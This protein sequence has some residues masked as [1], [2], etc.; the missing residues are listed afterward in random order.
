MQTTIYDNWGVAHVVNGDYA[1]FP[2]FFRLRRLDSDGATVTEEIIREPGGWSDLKLTLER[3]PDWHG[4]SAEYSHNDSSLSFDHYSGRDLITETFTAEGEDA[5]LLLQYGTRD[6]D[7]YIVE[8]EGRL[9]L[10]AYKRRKGRVFCPLERKSLASMVRSRW[11]TATDLFSATD[12]DNRASTPPLPLYVPLSPQ[13]IGERFSCKTT[14][15][16]R[17]EMTFNGDGDIYTQFNTSQPQ[18]SEIEDF[19]SGK[20]QGIAKSDGPVS[21]DEW[22]FKFATSGSR[23]I[24]LQLD[25][26]IWVSVKKRPI[27]LTKAKIT[28][29]TLRTRLVLKRANGNTYE[30]DVTTPVRVGRAA[31]PANNSFASADIAD[32]ATT[33]G[34]VFTQTVNVQPGDRLY[35]FGEFKFTHNLNEL[36]QVQVTMQTVTQR[37]D[38]EG[39]SE[40]R[41]TMAVGLTP[42]TALDSAVRLATG[43]TNRLRSNYY[44]AVSA[45]YPTAGPGS[46]R[47]LTTGYHLR[48]FPADANALA[49]PF[50]T[51]LQKLLTGLQ[52]IDGL[53]MA[54]ETE[55]DILGARDVIRV[56]P[57]R[58]FYRPVELLD[59]GRVGNYSEEVLTDQLL[60]KL[61]VG[62]EKAADED[63]EGAMEEFMGK[64]EACL[65]LRHEFGTARYVSGIIASSLLIERTRRVQ[66][67]DKPKESTA[68]DEDTFVIACR[69]AAGYEGPFKTTVTASDI[70]PGFTVGI[71]E[72][73]QSVSWI[74]P[75][76]PVYLSGGPYANT[77]V[78]VTAIA[79]N[80]RSP[81]TFTVLE[82]GS[83]LNAVVG[84]GSIGSGISNA[85]RPEVGADLVA[86]TGLTSADKTYNI[87]LSP[88]RNLI[89]NAPRWAGCLNLKPD[90]A[91]VLKTKLPQ[92]SIVSSRA[93]TDSPLIT[94]KAPL[95]VNELRRSMLI[96]PREIRCETRLNWAQIQRLRLGLTGLLPL[97]QDGINR[98][99]G[100]VTF[101]DDTGA[102]VKGYITN[103]TYQPA[104]GKASLQIRRGDVDLGDIPSQADC[105]EY[106]GWTLAQAEAADDATRRRIELCRY[107]DFD[108]L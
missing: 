35:L 42:E 96:T 21:Y 99:Y 5:T 2:R 71:V 59:L 58:Y 62:Y 19:A 37:I 79:E 32:A 49:Y 45:R 95:Q 91:Q 90:E 103:L 84:S 44:G 77:L 31:I 97:G 102:T 78:T 63:S 107:A 75:G 47:L 66:W 50:T 101:L 16:E 43:Y 88:A 81:W 67:T 74:V 85:L 61:V 68:Y 106:A 34:T 26:K 55:S 100:Y 64:I 7:T 14:G 17:T 12:L 46:A 80:S 9:V 105:D 52:A 89:R 51:S 24:S 23:K 83:L 33:A 40:S 98:N 72:L 82:T 4:V 73:P 41:G 93:T 13:A 76:T 20:P 38:I 69:P 53:G 27:G 29:Y 48:G 1:D 108:E 65:P 22:L 39:Q 92:N 30:W 57:M 6:N 25:W 104:T 36:G 94:E 70:I 87:R 15:G 10:S 54:F 11:E 56:E 60:S 3:D 86:V 8:Y 18:I 28:G